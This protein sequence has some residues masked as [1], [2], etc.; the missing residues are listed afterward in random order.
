MTHLELALGGVHRAHLIVVLV[1]LSLERLHP[2]IGFL[3]L[4]SV[5]SVLTTRDLGIR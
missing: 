2:V 3:H 4:R 5:V 1:D